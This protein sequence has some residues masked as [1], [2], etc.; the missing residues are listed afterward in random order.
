MKSFWISCFFLLIIQIP[1]H[2]FCQNS[3]LGDFS[4]AQQFMEDVAGRPIYLKLEY[5]V[6]GSPFYPDQY[7]KANVFLKSG[8]IYKD[9]PVR[10]NIEQNLVLFKQQNGTENVAITPISKIIFTDTSNGGE[11]AYKVFE[12]GFS[13]VDSL[14]ET[15]FYEVIQSG[16]IKLLKYRVV[17]FTDQKGYGQASIT[18]IFEQKEIMFLCKADGKVVKMEKGKESFLSYIS[19][20]Q[21]EIGSFIDKNNLKCRK[22]VD[23]KKIVAYYNSLF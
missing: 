2:L 11:V 10:F 21:T 7:Y 12:N 23:W 20:K 18:R 1:V 22:E 9:V 17:R 19:D 5:N 16:K 15:T 6:Q 8:K 14:S 3:R 4:N 13:P